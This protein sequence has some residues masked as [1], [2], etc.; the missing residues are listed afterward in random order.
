MLNDDVKNLALLIY[1]RKLGV[2][3]G[4][5]GGG[6]GGGRRWIVIVLDVLLVINLS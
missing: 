4:G 5:G 2:D 3:G 6:D 1:I